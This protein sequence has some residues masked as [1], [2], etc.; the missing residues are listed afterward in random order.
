MTQILADRSYLDW[1]FFDSRHGEL[2]QALD[3]WAATHISDAHGH[4]VDQACRDLVKQLGDAGWL[5][6]AIGGQAYSGIHDVIDTR[7]ICLLR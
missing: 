3:Q 2:Q 4:D 5:R 1:P 6:Y 7:A